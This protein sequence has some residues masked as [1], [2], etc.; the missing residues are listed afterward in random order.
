MLLPIPAG[1]L[2]KGVVNHLAFRTLSLPLKPIQIRV[3]L[4]VN[5]TVK[6]AGGDGKYCFVCQLV[7]E[8]SYS[9]LLPDFYSTRLTTVSLN[10][11]AV[12]ELLRAVAFESKGCHKGL[13][14]E[15]QPVP[16]GGGRERMWS[17]SG[18]VPIRPLPQYPSALLLRCRQDCV[19]T[20]RIWGKYKIRGRVVGGVS[21]LA[22]AGRGQ[23]A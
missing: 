15:H 13:F 19:L 22:E 17:L 23:G 2:I 12:S 21:H 20:S 16:W 7:N 5:E 8:S 10:K 9:H 11:V 6:G 3:V 14:N 18:L 4:E 1:K